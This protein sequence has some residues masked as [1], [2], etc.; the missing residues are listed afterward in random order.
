MTSPID[1][2]RQNADRERILLAYSPDPGK[3]KLSAIALGKSLLIEKY[4]LLTDFGKSLLIKNNY[5]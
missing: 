5:F 4:L 3:P 2:P 1:A